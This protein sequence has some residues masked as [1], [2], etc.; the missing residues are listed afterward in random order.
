[1]PET[2]LKII[3]ERY[4]AM[5][6]QLMTKIGALML[7]FTEQRFREQGWAGTVMQPWQARKNNTDPG[8]AILIKSGALRRSVYVVAK[9]EDNVT[10]GSDLP[11]AKIHNEGGDIKHY[12]RSEVFV[13]N[14]KEGRFV[15]GTTPGHGFSYGENNMQMPQRRFMG[16]SPYLR[17]QI[18]R[19]ITLE[20]NKCFK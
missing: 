18:R 8:R 5:R 13:R 6:Q 12:A 2:D 3:T 14:R 16:D 1:M 10:I 19:L 9:T 20:I 11:Y 7:E 15:K 4:Q 17:L